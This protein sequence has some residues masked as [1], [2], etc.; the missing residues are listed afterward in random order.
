MRLGGDIELSAVPPT[1]VFVVVVVRQS[2]VNCII[3]LVCKGR[4]QTLKSVSDPRVITFSGFGETL[5]AAVALQKPN[6]HVG[7]RI[8]VDDLLSSVDGDDDD[9]E[10]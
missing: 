4:V 1:A 6:R 7:P 2:L 10:E 9:E 8:I 5:L 3:L